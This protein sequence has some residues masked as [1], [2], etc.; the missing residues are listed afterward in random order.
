[1]MLTMVLA[2]TILVKIEPLTEELRVE[3]GVLGFPLDVHESIYESE[4]RIESF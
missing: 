4:S 3:T 1:M 2:T